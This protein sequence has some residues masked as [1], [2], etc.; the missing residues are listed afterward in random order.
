[1]SLGSFV[2]KFEKPDILQ[3]LESLVI[4][5]YLNLL[6]ACLRRFDYF[7]YKLISKPRSC[8]CGIP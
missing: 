5:N 1:M 7:P 8:N 4:G 3:K 2:N 6:R